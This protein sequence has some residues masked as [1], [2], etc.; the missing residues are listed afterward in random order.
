MGKMAHWRSSKRLP[1]TYKHKLSEL[2]TARF[3]RCRDREGDCDYAWCQRAQRRTAKKLGCGGRSSASLTGQAGQGRR[4]ALAGGLSAPASDIENAI[5]AIRPLTSPTN[6][7]TAVAF[8]Y[9]RPGVPRAVA[10]TMKPPFR[11][12]VLECDTPLPDVVNEF[13]TY[14]PIFERLLKAGAD[15]L[16]QPDVITSKD[17]QVSFYHVV[18]NEEAYPSLDDVD[19]VLL[20]GSSE[21][22]QWLGVAVLGYSLFAACRAQLV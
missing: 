8:A 2:S 5:T 19:A 17:L 21:F 9:H 18:D 6:P 3:G 16:G 4:Q 14:G 11:I 13:G 7:R 12:A 20:T 1:P 22:F 15:G 10:A